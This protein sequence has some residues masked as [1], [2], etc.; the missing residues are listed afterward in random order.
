[1][2]TSDATR[3][4]EALARK[5]LTVTDFAQY[6][7][8][9][10]MIEMVRSN[11][12]PPMDA[13][14]AILQEANKTLTM[15][16]AQELRRLLSSAQDVTKKANSGQVARQ[17]EELKYLRDRY[18]LAEPK[19]PDNITK[20]EEIANY[21]MWRQLMLQLESYY[22][23]GGGTPEQNTAF[24]E[25]LV[26]SIMEK[27]PGR[28]SRLW[29]MLGSAPAVKPFPYLPPSEF[30]KQKV[31]PTGKVAIRVRENKATGEIQILN[32]N[33]VWQTATPE[34]AQRWRQIRQKYS[35]TTK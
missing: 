11:Q 4:I 24:Y 25:G 3:Y 12:I 32:E 17:R 2:D 33:G 16:D 5:E 20:E 14:A 7:R 8:I 30:Q 29:N 1:M 27:Q 13:R 26:H 21:R 31:P 19:N 15:S 10:G 28:W 6:D 34:Q 35:P 18:M 23:Q 9:Y 22:E